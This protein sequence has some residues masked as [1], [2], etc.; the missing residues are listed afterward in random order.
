[1]LKKLLTNTFHNL[2]KPMN[3]AT[4][5]RIRFPAKPYHHHHEMKL[6]SNWNP[7]EINTVHNRF[8]SRLFNSESLK[9]NKPKNI[10]L[11]QTIFY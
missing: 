6:T 3:M 4:V 5:M 1:M 2:L 10:G 8:G 9:Q 11:N 7:A